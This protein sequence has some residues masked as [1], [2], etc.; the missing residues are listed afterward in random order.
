MLEFLTRGKKNI[1]IR[2]SSP[3]KAHCLVSLG[4]FPVLF[5]PLQWYKYSLNIWKPII[6]VSKVPK[7]LRISTSKSKQPW[8][9]LDFSFLILNHSLLNL[10][11]PKLVC[12]NLKKKDHTLPHLTSIYICIATIFQNTFILE[13]IFVGLQVAL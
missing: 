8:N 5:F 6:F 2:L 11:T 1:H 13:K 3:E 7:K 9:C 12:A 10:L 4:S